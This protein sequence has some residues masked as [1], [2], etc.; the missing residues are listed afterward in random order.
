M[1]GRGGGQ[2][3]KSAGGE[4]IK[5][6]P[7]FSTSR[8]ES[9]SQLS[10]WGKQTTEIS[11]ADSRPVH[12]A[13]VPGHTRCTS[14]WHQNVMGSCVFQGP[15]H[16]LHLCH[17]HLCPPLFSPNSQNWTCWWGW[18]G[19]GEDKFKHN[20]ITLKTKM[21]SHPS[22]SHLIS[23]FFRLPV[24]KWPLLTVTVCYYN[25]RSRDKHTHK[26]SGTSRAFFEN[27]SGIIYALSYNLRSQSAWYYGQPSHVYI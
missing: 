19:V 20:R 16:Q 15:L 13:S 14:Q 26:H 7:A 6:I 23:Y 18:G 5:F 27:K 12:P 3:W 24:E 25:P 4:K 1:Q 21:Q 22:Q 8:P 2:G 11:R 10:V 17:L 9:Q